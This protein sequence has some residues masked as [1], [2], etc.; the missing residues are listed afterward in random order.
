[1]LLEPTPKD[2]VK[3]FYI[4]DLSKLY[5]KDMTPDKIALLFYMIGSLCFLF[6]SLVLWFK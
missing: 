2:D 4:K 1:M 6:G 5:R 3:S